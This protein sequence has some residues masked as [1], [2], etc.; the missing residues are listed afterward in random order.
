MKKIICFLSVLSVLFFLGCNTTKQIEINKLIIQLEKTSCSGPC[1]VYKLQIGYNGFVVLEGVEN[2]E[3]IGFFKSELSREQLETLKV[4]FD[5]INF[6]KLKDSYKSFMMDLPTKYISYTKNGETKKI[7]AY[8]NVPK[9]L[10]NLIADLDNLIYTL[11]W[12]KMK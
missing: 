9:E 5:Q 11:K 3:K 12:T 1:P 2:L 8:D 10:N 6:F 7:E 4:R